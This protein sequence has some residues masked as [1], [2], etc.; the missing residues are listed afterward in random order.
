MS[1]T[2]DQDLH[3]ENIARLL[4]RL[5]VAAEVIGLLVLFFQHIRP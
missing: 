3:D 4:F 5:L 1:P 2:D